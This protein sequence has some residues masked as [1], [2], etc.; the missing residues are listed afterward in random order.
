MTCRSVRWTTG[1]CAAVLTSLFAAPLAAQV[2]MSEKYTLTQVID[3]VEIRLTGARPNVRGR[4]IF[5][6]VVP[7][8]RSWVAGARQPTILTVGREFRI[9]ETTIPAGS[10]S[11][12][13]VPRENDDWS[14]IVEPRTD[15]GHGL[16][17]DSTDQQY[18][19]HLTVTPIDHAE[20]L[21]WTLPSVTGFGATVRMAW[22]DRAAEFTLKLKP[23]VDVV[24]PPEVAA[25]VVG[26]WVLDPPEEREPGM[27]FDT[28]LFIRHAADGRLTWTMSGGR[29]WPMDEGEDMVL[30]AAGPNLFSWGFTFQGELVQ[31][32]SSA[33]WEFWGSD[34]EN[35]NFE[36]R[37][38]PSD[39]LWMSG[40]RKR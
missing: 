20:T 32:I 39:R 37:Y 28:I 24:V 7:W 13:V 1:L 40:T 2:Q 8:N 4:T 31:H 14:L 36:V 21:S 18:H 10:Y 27:P 19:A 16:D 35:T 15:V 33:I 23:S 25:A 29:D 9:N 3:S 30:V 5:G 26:D 22:A 6:D 17:P 12:W 11:L 34:G 38:F